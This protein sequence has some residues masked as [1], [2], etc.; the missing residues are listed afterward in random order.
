MDAFDIDIDLPTPND[1]NVNGSSVKTNTPGTTLSNT[2]NY[3]MDQ[4][5]IPHSPQPDPL[6]VSLGLGATSPFQ[7]GS[8]VG[9]YSSAA[10][11]GCTAMGYHALARVSQATAIGNQAQAKKY[12]AIAIGSFANADEVNS[13][14]IGTRSHASEARSVAIGPGAHSTS[15]RSISIGVDSEAS[16]HGIAIGD[17][18]Q[19]DGTNAIA[20]GGGSDASGTDSISI[21]SSSVASGDRSIAIGHNA[22]S[23][24]DFSIAVGD[25][26]RTTAANQYSVGSED[27]P[28]TEVYFGKGP[29]A[30][31][32][33]GY[34]VHGDE[35]SGGTNKAGGEL[36]LTG[37]R[38]TGNAKGGPVSLSVSGTG[39]SGTSLNTSYKRVLVIP[40]KSLTNNTTTE[41]FR[42]AMPNPLSLALIIHLG[43][44][45]S[46]G[47]NNQTLSQVVSLALSHDAGGYNSNGVTSTTAQVLGGGGL[48]VTVSVTQPA[49]DVMAVNVNS[50]TTT[51]TPTSIVCY[52]NVEI[53]GETTVTLV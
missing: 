42:V 40:G 43:V 46:D 44:L 45:V 30:T 6:A 4:V 10:A 35:A 49:T 14:A 18:A 12:Q 41:V 33:V 13:I 17:T 24:N 29:L 39:G 16:D 27:Y 52:L 25:S 48:T 8:A 50:N 9:A 32:P 37:G 15:A 23:T 5:G 31:T 36:N 19:A 28:L 38:S 11:L 1:G 20:L 3:I 2:A 21:G 7:G 51:L 34:S 47:T 26:S 22:R 53:L